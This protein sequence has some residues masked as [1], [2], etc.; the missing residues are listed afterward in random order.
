MSGYAMIALPTEIAD[1][2]VEAQLAVRPTAT[3]GPP[4]AEIFSIT[5]DCINT[6]SA[7]VSVAIAG[8]TCRRLAV[9]AIKRRHRTDPNIIT[10]KV[11]GRG[12]SK[13]LTVDRN[14]PSAEDD[15]LDFVIAALEAE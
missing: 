9:A 13:S 2:L 8:A 6:S 7:V 12:I 5:V 15:T 11:T 4:L 10:L 1:E 3:R 14:L